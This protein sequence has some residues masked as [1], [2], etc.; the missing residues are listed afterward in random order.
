MKTK[1]I[2]STA[3]SA[4]ALALVAGSLSACSTPPPAMGTSSATASATAT[5]QT[6]ARSGDVEKALAFIIEEEKLAYDV[7][8]VLGAKWDLRTMQNIVKSEATHQSRVET[9][10]TAY[11]VTD[12]RSS[13]I[14]VFTNPDLQKLYDD[15]IAQGSVSAA[16]AI[17]VG[18]LIEKTDIADIDKMLAQGLPNDLVTVLDVLKSGSINHLAAFERQQ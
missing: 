2:T 5:S 12:P 1:P 4:V 15:L 8:T 6:S 11:K 18:V 3:L 9:L 7:Y 13:A 14:G 17:G 16:A 10:L